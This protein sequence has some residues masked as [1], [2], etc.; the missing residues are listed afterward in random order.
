MELKQLRAAIDDAVQPLLI[1]RMELK[2][3]FL[4]MKAVDANLLI[5]PDGIETGRGVRLAQE[6]L[7]LLI[8]P[9]G[10]ATR[11]AIARL[12]RSLAFNRTGW[13]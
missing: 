13:N 5:A 3:G 10:I 6:V 2:P 12:R 1:A 11:D 8:A 4:A 7:G 9:D